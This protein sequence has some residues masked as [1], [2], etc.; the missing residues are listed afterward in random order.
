MESSYY[1]ID[2]GQYEPL[3]EPWEIYLKVNQQ[4]PFTKMEIDVTSETMMNLNLT[5]GST[6]CF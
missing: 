5:Y 3:M 6:L 2:V 4:L 1:N